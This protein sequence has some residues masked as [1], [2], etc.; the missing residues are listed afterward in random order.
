MTKIDER[1]YLYKILK[2]L[3][4]A[5]AAAA[6]ATERKIASPAIFAPFFAH[7]SWGDN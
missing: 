7:I 3:A 5:A 6:A 1:S 4:A 2:L